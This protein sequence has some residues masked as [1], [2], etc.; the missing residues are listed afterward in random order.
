VRAKLA[1]L[2]AGAICYTAAHFGAGWGH[3]AAAGTAVLWAAAV[4]GIVR[5]SREPW[6]P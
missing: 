5:M 6:W 4:Y 2:T 1:G 3:A